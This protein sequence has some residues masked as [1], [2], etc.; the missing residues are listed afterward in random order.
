MIKIVTA[1]MKSFK[2]F[3][4]ANDTLAGIEAIVMLLKNQCVFSEVNGMALSIAD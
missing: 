4:S 2:H 1:P 3:K